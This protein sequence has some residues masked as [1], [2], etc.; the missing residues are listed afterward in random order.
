MLNV[1]SPYNNLDLLSKADRQKGRLDDP[2]VKYAQE[3]LTKLG[4]PTKPDGDFGPK[5]EA[6]V[7]LFQDACNIEVNGVM[8]QWFWNELDWRVFDYAWK[9]APATYDRDS[10]AI[11]NGKNE[12]SGIAVDQ[13]GM[14]REGLRLMLVGEVYVGRNLGWHGA[15]NRDARGTSILSWHALGVANDDYADMDRDKVF[16]D[17]EKSQTK[18]LV[19]YMYQRAQGFFPVYQTMKQVRNGITTYRNRTWRGRD[20]LCTIVLG[21]YRMPDGTYVWPDLPKLRD[22][23]W[24]AARNTYK[25]SD[26]TV[27]MNPLHLHCDCA[28]GAPRGRSGF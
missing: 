18:A 23:S 7:K 11:E 26:N 17:W 1:G 24:S 8:N 16:E 9:A 20:R 21:N 2:V 27:H 28:P 3:A 6:S 14:T 22:V 25:G 19:D 12:Y 4:F 13:N 15:V 5:T 10:C